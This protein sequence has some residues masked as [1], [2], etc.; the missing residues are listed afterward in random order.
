[1][2]LI[3]ASRRRARDQRDVGRLRVIEALDPGLRLWHH[4]AASTP[5]STEACVALLGAE[6]SCSTGTASTR[7]PP[8]VDHV[9]SLRAR[10]GCDRVLA[11]SSVSG[12][13]ADLGVRSSCP[14]TVA[15]EPWCRRSTTTAVTRC[16]FPA[17]WRADVLTPRTQADIA[18]CDG[19]SINRY[20]VVFRRARRSGLLAHLPTSWG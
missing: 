2:V 15:L 6:P 4:D 1:M 16:H 20:P 17:S 9:A 8:I 3:G 5:R 13:R 11:V 19:V 10:G 18:V 7:T 12:L 14:T